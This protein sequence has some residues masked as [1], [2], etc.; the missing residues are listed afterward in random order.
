MVDAHHQH[1]LVLRAI[2]DADD[3]LGGRAFVDAPE[4]VVGE[5]LGGGLLE[6]GDVTADRVHRRHDVLDGAVLARG[7]HAL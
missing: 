2:E 3:A 7:V 4:E 6:A 1:I 5:L